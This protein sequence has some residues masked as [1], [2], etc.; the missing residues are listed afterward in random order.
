MTAVNSERF[1]RYPLTMPPTPFSAL[2]A[3]PN[4]C[5]PLPGLVTGG[6]PTEDQLE[7][8]RAAGGEVVLDIRAPREPRPLD[9]PAVMQRLG[10]EYVVVPVTAGTVGEETLER[11]LD[12]LR[13]A[14]GRTTLF[15]CASGNRV[16]AA[17][18]PY[19]VLDQ[20]MEEEDALQQAIRVGLTSPELMAWGLNYA[21]R[22]RMA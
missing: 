15:H 21:R 7:A 22:H 17:L 11:I 9:E 20:G 16:G 4:A 13:K 8:F 5:E 18:I 14:A 19:L 6:Q 2:A 12:A 3:I 10:L 1:S